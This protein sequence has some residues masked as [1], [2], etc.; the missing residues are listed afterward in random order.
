MPVIATC[1]HRKKE[2]CALTGFRKIIWSFLLAILVPAVCIVAHGQDVASATSSATRVSGSVA[3]GSIPQTHIYNHF[4]QYILHL[5][6]LHQDGED[7]PF[8][9]DFAER[10]LETNPSD[11]TF[12]QSEAHECGADVAEIDAQAHAIIASIKNKYPGGKIAEISQIPK[13]PERLIALQQE[14]DAVIQRHM[15]NLQRLMSK[16]SFARLD[17]NLHTRFASN[18]HGREL[19]MPSRSASQIRQRQLASGK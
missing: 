3:R 9:K 14:R 19:P 12:V 10:V 8:M 5:E 16:P 2:A 6:S 13:P 1:G 15:D 4:F 11:W 17:S 18:I 7:N